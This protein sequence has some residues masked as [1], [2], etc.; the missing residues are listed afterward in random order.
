MAKKQ[1]GSA[2]YLV[3]FVVWLFAALLA[4]GLFYANA[5]GFFN[6]APVPAERAGRSRRR[7]PETAQRAPRPIG[8]T[9]ARPSRR[10]PEELGSGAAA[11]AWR[12]Q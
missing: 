9:P 12:C 8:R 3:L 6:A 2:Q 1:R 4:V 11:C 7:R 10:R 5:I